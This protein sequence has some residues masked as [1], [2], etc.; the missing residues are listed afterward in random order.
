MD[1]SIGILDCFSR[2]LLS[3]ICCIDSLTAHPLSGGRNNKA[4][5]LEEKGVPAYVM[6]HYFRHPL[7]PR[8]RCQAEWTFLKYAR[9]EG[10][11]CVPTPIICDPERGIAVFEYI[12][13]KKI[14]A[15]KVLED[16]II[17]SL[18][19]FNCLNRKTG[20]EKRWCLSPASEACF[21]IRDHLDCVNRRIGR[22]MKIESD[23][24]IDRDA[25]FFI[26]S[27]LIPWWETVRAGILDQEASGNIRLEERLPEKDICISPSDFG[28]HN[29]IR[30][31]SGKIF[32]IDFEYSGRD[33]PV[34]M[35]CDF[36]CQPEVPIPRS[37]LPLFA[38]R[39]LGQLDNRGH[40]AFRL[41]L[42]LPVHTIKWC[43]ILLN[44]FLPVDMARRKF[45]NGDV[46]IEVRKRTQ[47]K[48]AEQML[49][50]SR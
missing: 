20:L 19:F 34:K 31:D 9:N 37:Y 4:F 6:K 8:D 41:D 29:A 14:L 2:D 12:P 32:F 44:D 43:C 28:F 38:D 42:L 25:D 11:S 7:D 26:R 21:S 48:K 15:D 36:F 49:N 13:G 46:D 24:E 17:Q 47:L 22:L 30:T 3:K 18:N 45:A 5:I 27:E 33:D 1:N 35:I 39:V 10:V 23:S 16:H 40:H 50:T